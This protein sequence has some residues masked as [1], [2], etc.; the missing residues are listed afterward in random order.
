[1]LAATVGERSAGYACPVLLI[2][3]DGRWVAS[4]ALLDQD[5]DVLRPAPSAPSADTPAFRPA[6]WYV[7]R[8]PGGADAAGA[9]AAVFGGEGRRRAELVDELLQPGSDGELTRSWNPKRR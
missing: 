2:M 3:P 4:W 5:R 6:G 8:L 7:S 9:L 1:M